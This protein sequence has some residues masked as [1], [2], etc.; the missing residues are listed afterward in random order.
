MWTA[1]SKHNLLASPLLCV[2]SQGFSPLGSFKTFRKLRVLFCQVV[3]FCDVTVMKG[4]IRIQLTR[5]NLHKPLFLREL[6]CIGTNPFSTAYLFS[7][8]RKAWV[9]QSVTGLVHSLLQMVDTEEI[10]PLRLSLCWTQITQ[11]V[12]FWLPSNVPLLILH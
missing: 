8:K 9:A 2:P 10:H 12:I 4:Y 7:K 3:A 1:I 11:I 5:P 6:N